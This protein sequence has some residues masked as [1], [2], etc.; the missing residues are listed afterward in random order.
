MFLKDVIDSVYEYLYDAPNPDDCKKRLDKVLEF[1]IR[2]RH[3]FVDNHKQ[4]TVQDVNKEIMDIAAL[5]GLYLSW[6][7]LEK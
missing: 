3:T 2:L 6:V 5:E 7:E 4:Q 1:V